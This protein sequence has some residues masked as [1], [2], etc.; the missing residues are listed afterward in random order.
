MALYRIIE[1]GGNR[2]GSR[3]ALLFAREMNLGIEEPV[4]Y[5]IDFSD[6]YLVKFLNP[7]IPELNLDMVCPLGYFLR[8]SNSLDNV[9][10]ITLRDVLIKLKYS[11]QEK[12][13]VSKEGVVLTPI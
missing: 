10:E 7:L 5:S 13:I 8:N 1:S 6:P 3:R 12:E 4:Q 2:I 9:Q 11:I